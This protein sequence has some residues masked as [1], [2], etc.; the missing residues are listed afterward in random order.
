[1][2][3]YIPETLDEETPLLMEKEGYSIKMTPI[4]GSLRNSVEVIQDETLTPYEEI[5]EENLTAVYTAED[6]LYSYEYTSLIN[7][8]KESLV[9]EEK[10]ESNVFSFRLET[11]GLIPVLEERDNVINLKDKDSEE[12]IA[13]IDR[14]FMNDASG[15]AYS[16]DLTYALSETEEDVYLV[17]LT[18]SKKYLNDSQRIYPVTIDPTATWKGNSQLSDAYVISG[19]YADTNFYSNDVRIMIAGKGTDGTHR[20]YMKILNLKSTLAD[21]YVD[22][23]YLTLYE[24]GYCD[25]NQTMR[26]NR[27]LES[28]S[29]STVTWNNKPSYSTTTVNSFTTEG[30][31][32]ASHKIGVTTLTRNYINST[33]NPNY[34]IVIRNATS[35]PK[36]AEFYGSRTSLTSY[37]PKLVVTYYDKPTAPESVST[38]RKSGESY[39]SSS[40]MREGSSIYAS[41]K[42]INSHNL[43]DVQYKIIAAD[44]ETPS[45]TSVSSDN[46]NLTTYRSLGVDTALGTNVK[47]PY[48]ASLPAGKYRL[49]IRGK[50]A[51]GMYGSAK[52][53]TFYVDGDAPS[54]TNVSVTPVTTA[55]SPTQN[56]NPRLT[57]TATDENFSKVTIMVTGGSEFTTTTS[58]GTKSVTLAS[59][60]FPTDGTYTIRVRVYDKAGK[61][62][63]K[64]LYYHVDTKG[65]SITSLKTTPDTKAGA[66]TNN[67]HPVVKWSIADD[68][69]SRIQ[70]YLNDTLIYTPSS[71]TTTSVSISSAR[72]PESGIYKFT[73]KV[74]DTAGNVTEKSVN[75]Y[76]D[77]EAPS[78]KTITVVPDSSE[79]SKA[80]ISS[81]MVTWTSES[82]DISQISYS[83]DNS[84][85]TMLDDVDGS[86]N[87]PTNIIAEGTNTI[88]VRLHDKAGNISSTS[89]LNYYYEPSDN[90]VPEIKTATE[91]YG[92]R[93][94]SWETDAFND[95]LVAYELHRGTSAGFTPSDS[96]LVEDDI[97]ET[98]GLFVD[99]EILAAGT[100]YY[101][102]KVVPLSE[103]ISFDNQF[104]NEISCTNAVTIDQFANNLGKKDYLDYLEVG[105]PVGT[106]Y[107]E[108]SSGNLFYT[109]D[110]FELSNS[111]LEY[112]MSRTYNSLSKR[113]SM[114]GIGWTDSYHKE[115]YTCGDDIYFGDSDGSSYLFKL[116][117]GSYVCEET[118]NYTLELTDTGYSIETKDNTVYVFNRSGQLVET[119]EPNNCSVTNTYDNL[120]RLQSVTSSESI[121]GSK[122]LT[123]VYDE[124]EFQLDYVTDLAGTKYAYDCTGNILKK[125]TISRGITES[126][127]YNYVYGNNSGKLETIEDGEGNP[128]TIAYSGEK[129]SSIAYPDNESFRLTYTTGQTQVDKL[130]YVDGNEHTMYSTETEFD[131]GTGKVISYTD[132][133]GNE[134]SYEY[135]SDNSFLVKKEKTVRGYESLSNGIVTVRTDENVIETEY[136]YDENDNVITEEHSNGTETTYTYDNEQNLL[137]EVSVNGE[138]EITNNSYTYDDNGNVTSVTD[139][140]TGT[141]ETYLY[142]NAN[143]GEEQDNDVS[144]AGKQVGVTV[145]ESVSVIEEQDSSDDMESDDE[146]VTVTDTT[147]VV[148]SESTY[149]YSED[150]NHQIVNTL[151]TIGNVETAV[152][153]EYDFMGRI[154]KSVDGDVTTENE[155]DFMGRIVKTTVSEEG[156]DAIITT[157]SYDDNGTLVSESTTGGTTKTYTYDSRNRKTCEIVSG[158][159][160]ETRREYTD[161]GYSADEKIHNGISERT[162]DYTYTETSRNTAGTI[163]NVKYI[164]ICGSTVKEVAG[165]TTSH[166]TYDESGNR[167]A[168]YITNTSGSDTA[169][170][171]SLYDADGNAF[172]EIR[173]PIV[174]D[175][176]YTIGE[177]TITT[178]SEN[179]TKGNLISQT[180]GNGIVT[181]YTY[182]DENRLTSCKIGGTDNTND[183]SVEY[184][185]TENL[186]QLMVITDANANRKVE[187][188]NWNGLVTEISDI[189]G[190]K[191]DGSII[192]SS[193]YDDKGRKIKESYSND[194]YI[195]YAYADSSENISRESAY[196]T[197]SGNE[198]ED[199]LESET[200]YTYDAQ[201]RMLTATVQKDGSTISS[202]SYTYDAEGKKLSETV[203]YGLSSAET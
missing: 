171:L 111:Q 19:T 123:F 127:S 79:T 153:E 85:F 182:D 156:R 174:T 69:L 60:R 26:I 137:S 187:K 11:D 135:V 84:S 31:Q 179:D 89:S 170:T 106:A 194:T 136:T 92:K 117:N 102:L 180:S 165:E 98:A 4:E 155:Y 160:M 70:L 48:G 114:L 142:T 100:Y 146:I 5:K 46:V 82:T 86:F 177:D 119:T 40:Y 50:D 181:S 122:I 9:L 67:V 30:T 195:E 163:I 154:V 83:T 34:G 191:D 183:I 105:T 17:T 51:G 8:I 197:A 186:E 3:Q 56:R 57:W 33:N 159:G 93:F 95:N 113:T 107:V 168:E 25:A 77:I 32:Y 97:D 94:I 78:F 72:F 61:Y 99:K 38:S 88:Y 173:Q 118:K 132:A 58:S 64:N 104:S 101:K 23:A 1:M 152:T 128:Y 68:S 80:H 143:E 199:S 162:E 139:N 90:F 129:V 166:Y 150:D 47:I 192:I 140:I 66:K 144:C 36:Y 45:P 161:Y 147:N 167:Y 39:I 176:A 109:Q 52:Y 124:G 21:K 158:S 27:V 169:L 196:R 108:K 203:N 49:Y 43:A 193:E 63:S 134:T 202:T 42:G 190:N 2:K 112:G 141:V 54:L 15:E 184:Y 121:S 120:G 172:A 59:S 62:V 14:P 103:S 37:R 178:Y 164:D 157:Y 138:D 7:G 41:W 91:Y 29:T 110:D 53:K 96:T 55:D 44:D 189:S 188:K 151:N 24:T 13:H 22:S 145:T 28:W 35:T 131:T 201:G 71:L 198:T 65:P 18:I 20:T 75:Y 87:I 130:I 115:I 6:E 149:R 81:P 200:T 185:S 175:G 116:Q 126:L 73:L 133:A 125:L 148:T 10:P 16:E 76:L 12:I 74:T